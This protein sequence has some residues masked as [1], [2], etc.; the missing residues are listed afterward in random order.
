MEERVAVIRSGDAKELVW[1]LE[2]PPI[3]TAGTSAQDADLVEPD[4]LPVYQ[5]GRGGRHTYHG[6]GQRVAYVLLDLRERGT[7]LRAY[8]H[9]LEEWVITALADFS[10]KGERRQG[11]VGVW[12]ADS[13]GGENKIAAIGVRVRHWV[14]FHGIALNVSPNLMYYSGIIPCGVREHGVTSLANLGVDASM[15]E[16]D[17]VLKRRFA[18]VFRHRT[19]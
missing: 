9:R 8:V 17:S 16:V 14:T 13:A 7:D 11:R 6:P 12:V 2:H 3:Y 4:R 5:T 15:D 10:V 19:D 18:E 1:L